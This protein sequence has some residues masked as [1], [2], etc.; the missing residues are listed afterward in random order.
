V[1]FPGTLPFVL[2]VGASNQWDKRKTRTSQDGEYWWGSNHGKGLDVMA[3]GVK[4]PTTDIRG[5]RGYGTSLFTP[6]FNGTS[7]AAPHAAAVAALIV[8]VRPDLKED[9][10]RGIITDTADSLSGSKAWNPET[11]HGRL[12]AYRALWTARRA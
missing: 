10:I 2:T 1:D 5:Q 3:P 11:G 6:T 12:N 8:S 4:I 9:V 7:S